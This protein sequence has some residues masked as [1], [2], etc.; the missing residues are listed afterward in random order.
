MTGCTAAR[1]APRAHLQVTEASLIV[2][3]GPAGPTRSALVER[4]ATA[5]R[6]ASG[7]VC[8]PFAPS[9]PRPIDP[10]FSLSRRVFRALW[11][12]VGLTARGQALDAA[13]PQRV[14]HGGDG[15]AT[16]ISASEGRVIVLDEPFSALHGRQREHAQERL[17]LTW[18]RK[19]L[20]MVLATSSVDEAAFLG[21]DIIL[22]GRSGGI[23]DRL[24]G[25]SIWRFA[26]ER[27]RDAV[28]RSPDIQAFRRRLGALAGSDAPLLSLATPP[29][30]PASGAAA[31]V[32]VDPPRG[33]EP[34]F[35]DPS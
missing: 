6:Q 21:T 18:A 11:D 14:G 1:P 29:G 12:T 9:P 22:M 15:P 20:T 7:V 35:H 8:H 17:A 27:D 16:D 25:E 33:A 24:E 4:I 34:V 3:L 26:L 28:D 2:V 31:A 19:G 13:L 10:R 23:A 32:V 30:R 5:A